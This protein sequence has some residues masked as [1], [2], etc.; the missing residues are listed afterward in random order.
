MH[1]VLVSIK[2]AG[3]RANPVRVTGTEKGYQADRSSLLS[4]HRETSWTS[5]Q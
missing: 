4:I 2:K 1:A 3:V 5:R